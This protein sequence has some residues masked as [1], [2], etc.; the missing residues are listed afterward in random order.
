MPGIKR[1]SPVQRV[2]RAAST[3]CT[4]TGFALQTRHTGLPLAPDLP[5]VPIIKASQ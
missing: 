1:D 3:R 5:Y 2:F 4:Q